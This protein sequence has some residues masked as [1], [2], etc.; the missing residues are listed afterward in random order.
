LGS[1]PLSKNPLSSLLSIK[2][3]GANL[4]SISERW[5]NT[6]SPDAE[7][8]LQ[9]LTSIAKFEGHAIGYGTAVGVKDA[10]AR[11]VKFGR[12]PELT[13]RQR[14]EAL[15]RK[16]KGESLRSIAARFNVSHTTISRL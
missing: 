8:L 2:A 9:M 15:A 10:K 1:S 12:P 7:V 13:P 11:G 14:T 4:Q 5:A 6:A 16:A 3:K